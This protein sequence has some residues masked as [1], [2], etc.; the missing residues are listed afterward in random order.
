METMMNKLGTELLAAL[1]FG[2]V[3]AYAQSAGV[4]H[5]ATD[6][7]G[8]AL[9]THEEVGDIRKGKTVAMFYWTWHVG[10]STENKAY[11]LSKIIAGH[12]EMVHD[13]DH[14]RWKPYS[15]QGTFFW[16]EPLFDFYDGKDKWVIRKQLEMLGAA[17][18]DV[19]FYDA[20]NGDYT[21]KEGYEAVGEV[22]AEA[23]ADGVDVPQFAFML[24]FDPAKTTAQALVQ[25]YDELYK[26]GKYKDSWFM[27]KGKPVIMAH[28]VSMDLDGL[29]PE[30][31]AK[32]EAIKNFFTFRPGQPT[33][34]TGPRQPDHWGWLDNAP[35]KGYFKK[36]SGGYEWATVGV[37][38]N[39]SEKTHGLSAMSG[40]E[41]HG[42]SYTYADGFGKLTA[43]SYLYGYNFQEQWNNALEIDPD[44][45]F[46]TGWNEWVMGRFEEW[47]GVENAFPD[48][49]D[50][51][52]SRDIEPMKGGYGDNYY[53]QMI[54]NIRKFK[55]ME[56]PGMASGNKTIS[57]D[58]D[59]ADWADVK[60][61]FKASR[62]NA[63]HRDGYG[64]F[65][66]DS[67]TRQPLHYTNDTG[68]NDI[69][70]A[71]VAHDEAFVYFLVETADGLTSHTD[72]NWMHLFIDAD[73]KKTSGWEGY[74]FL[75]GGYGTDGKAVLG[76][77]SGG[78]TWKKVGQVDY[79]ITG[80]KM[81]IAVP[82]ALLGWSDGRPLDLEFKWADNSV[83][84]GEI[85]EFYTQG[86]VAPSGRF[87]YCYHVLV[88]SP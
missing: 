7:L 45:I 33:Y 52:H 68:R 44:I 61:G 87:N 49:F 46:I 29:P 59:F 11:D 18:V 31:A 70:G 13:C 27:W 42:R 75:V 84:S 77:S 15:D 83:G 19:L 30:I 81:E 17:G 47:Q 54:A 86:D 53:Y 5:P 64:Y 69:I 34:D 25:L 80:S 85:M 24:N 36:E 50:K 9:P 2:G 72:E 57:I 10:H 6:A 74:D 71:K 66:P 22:M 60:P 40:P 55:G 67:P 78:W 20:T 3:E 48:A 1:L 63:R 4:N 41:I 65:D 21:W 28:S 88:T 37:A 26:P 79:K 16:T 14:P 73:R 58:G 82:L 39:W 38:Q 62:G 23:R 56:K 35:R 43:D 32:G 51:E 12:P 8:R 76:R